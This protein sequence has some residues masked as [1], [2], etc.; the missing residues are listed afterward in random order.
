MMI[1]TILLFLLLFNIDY[2]IPQRGNSDKQCFI[3][4]NNTLQKIYYSTSSNY[5]LNHSGNKAF[6]N[7]RKSSWLSQRDGDHWIEIDFATKRL[8]SRIVVYSGRKD[9]YRAVKYCILQFI[10]NDEWFDYATLNFEENNKNCILGFFFPNRRV[11]KER[12][13][14]DLCGVD[15]SA[16]RIFIPASATY[17]GYAAIAE[18][19][20]YIGMNNLKCYDE[21]LMGLRFPINNGFLP[22]M[23]SSYPNAPREYR[24]GKHVGL[25]IYYYHSEDSYDPIGVDKETPVIAADNGIILR[26]DWNYIPMSV[27]EWKNQSEYYK[28]HP[29][30]FV[31]RSFG[32]RQIW[33]DHRNGVI[34]T[35]NHLSRIDKKIVRGANVKKGQRIGWAGNSGLLGEAEGKDYGIHLHFEI[36]VDGQYLGYGMNIKD[37][38][39]YFTW[40]F[41]I[42]Q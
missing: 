15:A 21:R 11:Y 27:E 9:N 19:E 20:T 10:H 3:I 5:S 6:D 30:T 34:S 13:E 38:R 32:G 33:I 12:V 42:H 31:K 24:G 1:K 25:D 4:G 39:K 41:S 29:C 40:I 28:R 26:A 37:I 14:F 23:D 2:K 17:D 8:M 22:T 36:W 35:Y 16:F 18:I 7:D